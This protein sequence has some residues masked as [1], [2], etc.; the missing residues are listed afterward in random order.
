MKCKSMWV[1]VA[2]W[3]GVCVCV[4]VCA[5]GCVAGWEWPFVTAFQ[6][7]GQDVANH[8]ADLDVVEYAHVG[9]EDECQR[10]PP[11][12]TTTVFS[13]V[14]FISSLLSS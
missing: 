6:G 2:G 3:Q 5:G 11:L 9:G 12:T 7:S 14:P 1:R 8:H 10:S 13:L 4:R